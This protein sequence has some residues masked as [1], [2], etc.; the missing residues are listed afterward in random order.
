MKH[1]WL[2]AATISIVIFA[3]TG[4]G[5]SVEEQINNGVASAQSIFEENSQ[6]PNQA[7]GNIEL[8]VPKGYTIKQSEDGVNLL[9]QKGSENYILFVNI[10][11]AEDSTLHYKILKNN[12]ADKIVKEQT[13]ELDGAFGFTAVVK[14]GEEQFELIVSS[15]GVKMSTI[16]K[17]HN[18]DSKLI[19]MM[20]IVRSVNVTK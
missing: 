11:E 7:V 2:L 10:N 3:L 20:Q 14:Y 19:E 16:S 1:R 12:S 15:G 9:L 18:I 13:V 6:Q 4:C 17:D 5:K 8:Y